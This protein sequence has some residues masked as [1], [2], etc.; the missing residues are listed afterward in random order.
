MFSFFRNIAENNNWFVSLSE[1]DLTSSSDGS[2]NVQIQS[3][4]LHPSYTGTVNNVFNSEHDIALFKLP[5]A[6]NVSSSNIGIVCLPAANSDLSGGVSVVATGWGGKKRCSLF[7]ILS[8]N[9][10]RT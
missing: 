10:N 1:H 7:V 9:G 5:S 6:V 3:Y 2:M 8:Y 4:F